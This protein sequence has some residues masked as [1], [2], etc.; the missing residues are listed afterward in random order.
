MLLLLLPAAQAVQ[1]PV[2]QQTDKH[3]TNQC[4]SCRCSLHLHC[5]LNLRGQRGAAANRFSPHTRHM[6]LLRR[7]LAQLLLPA[8]VPHQHLRKAV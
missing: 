3:A 4:V 2:K 6:L 1:H 5:T 7:R 8:P